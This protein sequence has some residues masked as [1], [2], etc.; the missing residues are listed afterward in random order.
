[1]LISTVVLTLL[2]RIV[3]V[4]R[5]VLPVMLISAVAEGEISADAAS[6]YVTQQLIDFKAQ[7]AILADPSLAAEAEAAE[8]ELEEAEGSDG[9]GLDAVQM[10]A[11]AEDEEPA[12][13]EGEQQICTL[14]AAADQ[15][16]VSGVGCGWGG[17]VVGCKLVVV[18]VWGAVSGVGCA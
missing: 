11:P 7:L 4:A 3:V 8:A 6:L 1:M 5:V 13:A 15:V 16:G 14:R 18:G 2:P 10:S 17:V 9:E 12:A